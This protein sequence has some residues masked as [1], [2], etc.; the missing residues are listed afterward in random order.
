MIVA[1]FGGSSL[2]NARQF[3]KVKAIVSENPERA[4]I[5]CSAPGKEHPEDTKVTDLL[6]LLYD[7]ASHKISTMELWETFEER[8]HRIVDSLH[9]SFDLNQEL[10]TIR[11]KLLHGASRDYLAS[12]GEYLTAK[13]MAQ[14][15]GYDFVDAKEMIFF[16][17]DGTLD[18]EKTYRAVNDL[19]SSHDHAVIPGFYGISPD[20]TIQTFSRG[21]G[22]LTGAIVARGLGASVYE[23]WTDVN[24]FRSADPRLVPEARSID[25][26]TYRELRELSYM[27]ANVLHEEAIFPVISQG[28]PIVIRNTNDPDGSSTRIVGE[29]GPEDVGLPITGVAGKKNFC[30]ITVEKVQMNRDLGFYRKVL[31][32]LE[33][34]DVPLEHMPSSIDSLSL[35]V[36]EQATQGKLDKI[37]SAIK[38]FVAPDRIHVEKDIALVAVVGRSMIHRVGASATLFSALAENDINIR[39]IIQG[40]SEM[41]I[42]LGVT[43]KDYEKAIATIYRAFDA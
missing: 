18:E 27:G 5:V 39:M 17:E 36:S 14:Y 22:D 6:Y 21:G 12:R 23:N 2:A 13:L 40:S 15:L 10:T 30:V 24:G 7:L 26:I 25:T 34:N 43:N 32:V 20:G 42:I 4:Y 19:L 11:E 16:K 37:T 35:I 9:L 41:N 33:A 1:K 3:E 8:F 28:I 31:S 38:T 29:A